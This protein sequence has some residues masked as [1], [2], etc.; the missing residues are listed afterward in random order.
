MEPIKLPQPTPPRAPNTCERTLPLTPLSRYLML[1]DPEEDTTPT[2]TTA[3]QNQRLAQRVNLKVVGSSGVGSGIHRKGNTLELSFQKGTL[4]RDSPKVGQSSLS[5]A[6][7]SLN[8]LVDGKDQRTPQS[9]ERN[10]QSQE[11][12]SAEPAS[13]SLL[14]GQRKISF[15]S[16]PVPQCALERRLQQ[17]SAPPLSPTAEAASG[18]AAASPSSSSALPPASP[19]ATVPTTRESRSRPAASSQPDSPAAAGT[20]GSR[21]AASPAAPVTAQPG[22]TIV[23]GEPA[24]PPPPPPKPNPN[25]TPTPNPNPNPNSP[26]VGRPPAGNSGRIRFTTRSSR[27]TT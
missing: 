17:I 9:L 12:S 4:A 16:G 7:R 11:P 26:A 27:G 23:T 10:A 20:P 21:A 13:T 22:T 25:H 24:A 8:H 14:S 19:A 6:N 18:A 15:G 3:D 5:G 2:S 1:P